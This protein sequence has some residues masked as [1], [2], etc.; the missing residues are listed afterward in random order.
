M[1]ADVQNRSVAEL[2]AEVPAPPATTFVVN[3]PMRD[4]AEF[5]TL[6]KFASRLKRFGRV[7]INISALA[8]KARHEVPPQGSP[9]HEYAACNPTPAKFFPDPKLEPFVPH[10]F[11]KRNR[12]L[13]L[14]KAA[15]LREFGLGAAFW[16]Y[17]PNFLPEAF[18]EKY[19]SMRGPRTDHPRR[20]RQE[21]FAP[22][23]DVEE[24]RE[25]TTAMVAEI[26][27]NVPE[28]G[29]YFFKTND[30]GPGL[31]WSDWQYSG[32]NGPSKCR[33]R[34][35]G[36]RVRDL[37][38]SILRGGEK[39]GAKLT[40]HMTGNFSSEELSTIRPNLP[41]N[42]YVRE[43]GGDS[44]SV[45]SCADQCYPVRGILDLIGTLN[46]L[47]RLNG[48]A[49]P[50]VFI[51]L[52][53]FYDRGYEDLPTSERIIEIITRHLDAP[54]R[55]P[56]EVLQF[57]Q[58]LCNDWV[59]QEQGNT[60]FTAMLELNEAFKYKAA[61]LPRVSAIYGGVSLRYITRPLLAL[62]ERLTAEEE[63]YFLPHVFNVSHE[64]ARLD[65]IDVHG[66]RQTPEWMTADSAD[67][68]IWAI[69][70]LAGQLEGVA[71][72][73]ESLRDVPHDDYWRCMSIGVRLYASVLRSCGNFF[74]VQ[75]IRDRSA[76]TFNGHANRFNGKQQAN[77]TGHP[78]L[79]LLN[80]I[81]RDELDNSAEMIELLK[82]G[83]PGILSHAKDPAD[84]DTFLLGPNV[85]EQIERKR[86]LMR[87]HWLDAEEYLYTP[88]K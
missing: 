22:C 32:P 78:D 86:Q 56:I 70:R 17:E 29:T 82:R 15:V 73:L 53:S 28:L 47:Q 39:G 80:E 46:A 44:V 37:M 4:L 83:G 19:P 42:A 84:E 65:Y 10:D 50:T 52:R 77:G 8:E 85:I 74:A 57:A 33:H 76:K 87:E 1:I 55:G 40:V 66:T 45:G 51:D 63:S 16:S 67:P 79:M 81:M 27:R 72:K 13:L 5:R 25:M 61:A 54:P 18:F 14:A 68:R 71:S 43:A 88:N 7:E 30:A 3:T 38:K 60:L 6:A 35:M 26:A 36:D 11:V 24:T 64:R 69:N 49:V 75:I 48:R 21:E 20:S 2:E 62:P 34:A 31:C 59:G 23:I 41:E 9:W 58:D 12:E